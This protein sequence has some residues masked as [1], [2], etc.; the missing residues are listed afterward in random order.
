MKYWEKGDY[1]N[2]NLSARKTWY[3]SVA[4]AYQ[5]AR[6]KYPQPL[7]DRVVELT[8]IPNSAHILEIGCGLF[9]TI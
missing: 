5:K 9:H 1:S 4:E 8:Q 2:K 3:S 6:P 7:I